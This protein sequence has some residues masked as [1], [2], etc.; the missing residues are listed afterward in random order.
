MARDMLWEAVGPRL[1][2]LAHWQARYLTQSEREDIAQETYLLFLGL[3][4]GWQRSE[5]EGAGFARYLF[6]IE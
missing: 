6:G 1:T 4:G 5:T 2:R 3:V